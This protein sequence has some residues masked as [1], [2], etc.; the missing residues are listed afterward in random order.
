[1]HFSTVELRY[2]LLKHLPYSSDWVLPD[3]HRFP[4]SAKHVARYFKIKEEVVASEGIARDLNKI[5]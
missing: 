5:G 4:I 1:M 3:Y 2:N